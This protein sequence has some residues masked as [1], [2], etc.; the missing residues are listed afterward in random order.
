[1]KQTGTRKQYVIFQDTT[2]SSERIDGIPDI[3]WNVFEAS[4]ID[5]KGAICDGP[6]FVC[7]SW[8]FDSKTDLITYLEDQGH[9]VL[10]KEEAKALAWDKNNP[11]PPDSTAAGKEEPKTKDTAE[12]MR[13][14]PP[15]PP[16]QYRKSLEKTASKWMPEEA[17]LEAKNDVAYSRKK[18]AAG[19]KV[20]M[21]LITIKAGASVYYLKAIQRE[22]PELAQEAVKASHSLSANETMARFLDKHGDDA[23]KCLKQYPGLKNALDNISMMDSACTR[24]GF[25][26]DKR[27]QVM[28]RVRK[29][30]VE[31]V[32]Q[33][34]Q[35]SPQGREPKPAARAASKAQTPAQEPALER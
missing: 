18:A 27:N 19:E 23:A 12:I 17:A 22:A 20:D 26:A 6:D 31:R 8:E 15:P 32:G 3:K 9:T 33:G 5:V 10:S 29:F 16:P 1:M 21:A 34:F 30:V 4:A 13:G 24:L 7:T 11:F 14:N 28:S 2:S 35:F 25:N